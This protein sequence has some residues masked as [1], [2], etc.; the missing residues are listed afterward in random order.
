MYAAPD[1]EEKIYAAPKPLH[2]AEP[3]SFKKM[4]LRFV[5][6]TVDIANIFIQ[7]FH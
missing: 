6:N 3:A 1:Y 2:V 5:T 7:F 4:Q